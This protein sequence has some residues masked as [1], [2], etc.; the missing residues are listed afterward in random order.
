M[1]N[2][3]LAKYCIREDLAFDKLKMETLFHPT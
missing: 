1:R 2:Q 3:N